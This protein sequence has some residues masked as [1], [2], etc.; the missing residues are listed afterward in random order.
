MASRA[1]KVDPKKATA[2]GAKTQAIISPTHDT[3]IIE[4]R[5]YELWVQRGCPIGS[6]EVDWY[7]AEHEIRG[8]A[9]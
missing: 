6:P 3:S 2:S 7:Q 8:N 5:A 1:I 9:S 4:V